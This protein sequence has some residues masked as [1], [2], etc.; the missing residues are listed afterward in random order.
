MKESRGGGSPPRESQ[1][2]EKGTADFLKRACCKAFPSRSGRVT[3]LV[4]RAGDGLAGIPLEI[5]F[6]GT[7]FAASAPYIPTRRDR[8]EGGR[9]APDDRAGRAVDAELRDDGFRL[10][11]RL[12]V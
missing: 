5:S 3:L 4:D 1:R 6:W 10:V 12:G 2:P 11:G 7:A 8:R 9:S